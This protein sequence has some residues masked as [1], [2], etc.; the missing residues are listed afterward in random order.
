MILLLLKYK[1]ILQLNVFMIKHFF[2]KLTLQFELK[3][4]IFI[5]VKFIDIIFLFIKFFLQ[6]RQCIIE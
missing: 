3:S 4:A 6:F 2:L 1:R 5:V